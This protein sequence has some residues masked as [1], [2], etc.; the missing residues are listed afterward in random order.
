MTAEAGRNRRQVKTSCYAK[1]TAT[2]TAR[3]SSAVSEKQKENERDYSL[4][5]ISSIYAVFLSS[6]ILQSRTQPPNMV[7]GLYSVLRRKSNDE[8]SLL[9]VVVMAPTT[10]A[11]C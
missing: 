5:Y 6:E 3:T 9:L 7:R 2:I 11:D 8:L 1:H 10:R 4:Q